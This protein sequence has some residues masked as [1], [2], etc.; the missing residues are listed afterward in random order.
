MTPT[1]I[2]RYVVSVLWQVAISFFIAILCTLALSIVE[3]NFGNFLGYSLD[4]YVEI[5]TDR[6]L[7]ISSKVGFVN[8]LYQNIANLD[9]IFR[10][11]LTLLIGA[12]TLKYP[13]KIALITETVVSMVSV[14]LYLY[15]AYC[16]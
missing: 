4:P 13:M 5:S 1:K 9:L 8:Y 7:R 15:A 3:R 6:F 11:G 14:V 10:L 16:F 2:K 12:L